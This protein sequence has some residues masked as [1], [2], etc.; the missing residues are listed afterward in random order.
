MAVSFDDAWEV[1]YRDGATC[2]VGGRPV[3][4]ERGSGWSVHHRLPRGMGGRGPKAAPTEGPDWLLLVC[5]SGTSGCHGWLESV[6]RAM[7]YEFGYL[8]RRPG[9]RVPLPDPLDI[10]VVPR[11]EPCDRR[12][13]NGG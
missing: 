10:P 8:I 2:R 11:P 13:V 3:S 5:G 7:A 9:P 1:F 12:Y 4:G 6:E